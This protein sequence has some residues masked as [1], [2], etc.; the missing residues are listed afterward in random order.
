MRMWKM[1]GTLALFLVVLLGSPAHAKPRQLLP[2][3]S[4]KDVKHRL[5]VDRASKRAVRAEIGVDLIPPTPPQPRP[6]PRP[7]QGLRLVAAELTPPSGQD[8]PL[9]AAPAEPETVGEEAES[10]PEPEPGA[11]EEY[12]MGPELEPEPGDQ[13]DAAAPEPDAAPDAEVPDMDA[14][15]D[16]SPV[17]PEPSTAVDGAVPESAEPAGSPAA[18]DEETIHIV[19]LDGSGF[20]QV[21]DIR[22]PTSGQHRQIVRDDEG[23]LIEIVRDRE[24]NMLSA[25]DVG[26]DELPQ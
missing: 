20:T 23:R 26:P 12:V 3:L 15:P 2:R 5:A 22:S 16:D 19:V 18:S 8:S 21:R 25:Q 9:R 14:A 4:Q 24:G 13:P 10:A 1:G 11:E 6:R 17:A 7:A